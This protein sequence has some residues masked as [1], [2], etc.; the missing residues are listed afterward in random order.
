MAVNFPKENWAKIEK[1][2]TSWWRGEL[3]R[4]LISVELTG[5]APKMPKPEVGMY[6]SGATSEEIVLDWMYYLSGIKYMGDAFPNIRPCLGAGV[7]AAYMGAKKIIGDASIWFEAEK[8][9]TPDE[10]HLEYIPNEQWFCKTCEI[11]RIAAEMFDG[12]VCLE[13][14]DICNGIDPVERFFSSEDFL[15][16][17]YEYPEEV[18]RLVWECHELFFKYYDE[19]TET[20]GKS[21]PGHTCWGPMF[22]KTPW[23]MIQSDFSCMV[24]PDMFE[25]FIFPE[26]DACC[27]KLDN[28]F[29]HLDGPGALKHLDKI[30]TIPELKGIQWIPGDGQPNEKHWP[31][32]YKKIRDAGKLIQIFCGE[33]DTVDVVAEQIGS[34]KGIFYC[35]QFDISHEAEVVSLL[36]RWGC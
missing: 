31:E 10:L 4:P 14:T 5:V 28:A 23:Y 11:Y 18:K 19:L 20:M 21:N 26:L 32:V 22:S 1:D 35:A 9:M 24:G 34:G 16:A 15:M 12:D 17:L 2:Y 6:D 3:D 29:Y 27:K 30:L 33:I 13:M 36:N 7:N 25:E 8:E